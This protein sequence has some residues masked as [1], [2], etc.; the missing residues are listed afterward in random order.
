MNS[1]ARR[2]AISSTKL[3]LRQVNSCVLHKSI[4]GP[5]LFN[6]S[7]GDPADGTECA[8]CKFTAAAKPGGVVDTEMAVL[9][10][11]WASAGWTNGL[12]GIT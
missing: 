8:L 1:Q 9:P 10:F 6:I 11:R 5:V 7:G 4:Q 12:R 2:T 3:S